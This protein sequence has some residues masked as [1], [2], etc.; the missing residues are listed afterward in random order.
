MT[1]RF[2][3]LSASIL[4]VVFLLSPGVPARADS[5][6]TKPLDAALMERL[7]ADPLDEIDRELFAPSDGK[8]EPPGGPGANRDVSAKDDDDWKRQLLRELDAAAGRRF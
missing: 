4:A 5:E 7:G 1:V 8:S 2:V 6:K 3:P